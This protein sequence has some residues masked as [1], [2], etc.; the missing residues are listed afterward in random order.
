MRNAWVFVNLA[1]VLFTPLSYAQRPS[2]PST[3]TGVMSAEEIFERFASR[4]VFL[5]CHGSPKESVLGSGVLISADGLIITNAHLV[6]RCQAMTAT[7]IDGS[8]RHAYDAKLKYYDLNADMA[9]LKIESSGL[10][11]F[12]LAARPV[13]IG[14]RVFAIG[15]PKGLEQ[16]ISEGIVSGN[17]EE[18]G[19]KWIQHTAPIS[20]GN[21]GGALI[22]SRGEL[23]GINTF[24]IEESQNLNFAIPVPAVALAYSGARALTGVL[25]FPVTPSVDKPSVRPTQETGTPTAIHPVPPCFRRA[26]SQDEP[27]PKTE[28]ASALDRCP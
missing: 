13:R 10:D 16:T 22:S 12:Q 3:A 7:H 17:R 26:P 1:V 15:N 9:V 11:F 19:L 20:P 18:D 8:S 24:S 27:A 6:K 14:E 5:T 2:S 23:L 21:S 28:T 25:K 4:I